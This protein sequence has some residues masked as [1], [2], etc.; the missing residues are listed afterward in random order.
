M[1]EKNETHNKIISIIKE[2]GP[3]L[4]IQIAKKLGMSSLFVSA[5]LSE[6]AGE[7][8]LKIS[9]LKVGGSPLYYLSGQETLLENFQEYLNNREIEAINLLKSN[10]VLKDSEQ[11][12]VV[13]VALRSL[14][15][16][17]KGF[18]INDEIYWRFYNISEEQAIDLLKP[19]KQIKQKQIITKK[20]KLIKPKERQTDFENPLILKEKK[21]EKPKSRFIEKMIDFINTKHNIIEEKSYKKNEYN[22]IIQIKS[23]LGEI[24]FLTQA[25][26]KKTISEDDIKKLLS[27]AQKIPLPALLIYTGSLSKKAQKLIDKY[28]SILKTKKI[29]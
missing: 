11:E 9:H 5:F 22:C 16:F 27:N 21:K 29:S 24:N 1:L 3:S 28:N 7:N 8:K 14:R 23:E 12:P 15:D 26:D 4:P 18:K 17:S 20:I 13:R 10:R 25:K 2:R 19:K 6:L